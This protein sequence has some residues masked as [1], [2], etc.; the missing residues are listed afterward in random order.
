MH[1]QK[2]S[3]LSQ[4]EHIANIPILFAK[5]LDPDKPLK[6]GSDNMIMGT[7][8]FADMYYVGHD[9]KGTGSTRTS[10]N[11][12]EFQ[13]QTL[14]M[15][16]VTN[17]QG[18]ETATGR[19]ISADGNNSLLSAMALNL[20]DTAALVIKTMAKFVLVDDLDVTIDIHTDYGV[21]MSSE[22]LNALSK[23]YEEE[24]LTNEEYLTELK[25]RGVLRAGFDIEDNL[26][27]IATFK[28][29]TAAN[30]VDTD[31]SSSPSPVVDVS[32][33]A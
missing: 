2:E 30:T 1:Y 9:A 28:A 5:G 17:K 18:A 25:R 6:I 13:M 33:A 11:S 16:F 27:K 23:A 4:T 31:S 20:A 15:E 19:A 14:C 3:D 22:E 7:S 24:T 10:I 29:Q 21:T 8:E 12:L 26:T 32:D